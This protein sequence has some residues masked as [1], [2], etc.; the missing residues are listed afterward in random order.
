[1]LVNIMLSN[2]ITDGKKLEGLVTFVEKTLLPQGFDVKTNERVYNN[3]GV[4]IAEFDIE[5]REK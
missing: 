1:M 3:D 5:I 4:Q 2:M